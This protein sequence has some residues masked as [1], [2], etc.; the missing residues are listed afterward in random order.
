VFRVAF[1]LILCRLAI[2]FGLLFGHFLVAFANAYQSVTGP[3]GGS[4]KRYYNRGGIYRLNH[5]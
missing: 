2:A 5:T 4:L 3:G 1:G